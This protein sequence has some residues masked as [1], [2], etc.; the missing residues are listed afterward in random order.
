MFSSTLSNTTIV[1]YSEYPR[2]V[3]K[4][5]MVAGVTSNPERLYTPI[6]T[7]MSCTTAASA[8]TAIFHSKRK[9]M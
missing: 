3:R 8:A 7:T 5:M 4:A 1:S 6:V 2:M 9:V